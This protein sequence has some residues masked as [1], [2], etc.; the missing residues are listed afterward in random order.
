MSPET[1]IRILSFVLCVDLA[2]LAALFAWLW[3]VT[4]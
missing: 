4:P 3:A 2:V 1:R